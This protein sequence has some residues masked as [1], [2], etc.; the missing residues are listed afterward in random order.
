MRSWP[1]QLIH[2]HG[3]SAARSAEVASGGGEAHIHAVQIEAGGLIGPH[4]AGFGQLFL[5]VSGVGWAA[6]ADR[7]RRTLEAGQAAFIRRGEVH[8]KGADSDLLAV[9][10]QVRDLDDLPIE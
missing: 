1:V 4:E 9:I 6:G 2:A 8:S 5:V 10:L 3:S 7:E